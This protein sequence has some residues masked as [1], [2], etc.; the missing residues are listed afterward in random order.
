ML[1]LWAEE[2]V[3]IRAKATTNSTALGLMPK[4]ASAAGVVDGSG[5]YV[6]YFGGTHNV[7]DS[8]GYIDYN[9]WNKVTYKGITGYVPEPCMVPF[10]P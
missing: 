6:R 10:K 8:R 9:Q 2:S 1:T 7:C 5:S 3:R 4:G